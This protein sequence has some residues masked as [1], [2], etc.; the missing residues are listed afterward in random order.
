[1]YTVTK[2]AKE[3]KQPRGGFLKPSS[4]KVIN[5]NDGIILKDNENISPGIVGTVV[6]YMTRF[7]NDTPVEEAF[8]I[9][10]RGA[11]ILKKTSGNMSR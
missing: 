7:I 4:F 8:V 3:F 11:K 10:L 2:R 6:D 9:S 1:M 5:L